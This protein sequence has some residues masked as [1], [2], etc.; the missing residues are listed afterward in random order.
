MLVSS[1]TV[2]T[3]KLDSM[4]LS[5]SICSTVVSY[6]LFETRPGYFRAVAVVMPC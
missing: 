2:L 6:F 5:K 4:I 1:M 3:A